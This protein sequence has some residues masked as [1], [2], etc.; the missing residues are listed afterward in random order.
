MMVASDE[1][2]N[3]LAPEKASLFACL[4]Q[5]GE[6]HGLL[7]WCK[8]EIPEE[9]EVGGRNVRSALRDAQDK[10]FI[11]QGEIAGADKSVLLSEVETLGSFV[12]KVA[13]SRPQLQALLTPGQTE[14][15]ARLNV[16][17]AVAR[18][19]EQRVAELQENGRML[20]TSSRTYLNRLSSL[21]DALARTFNIPDV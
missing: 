9:F 17:R 8:E 16:T 15:S 11:I 2:H 13:H 1:T 7:G 14:L 10:L 19:I 20:S 12:K 3:I 21:L 6:L 18:R 5:L 4:S